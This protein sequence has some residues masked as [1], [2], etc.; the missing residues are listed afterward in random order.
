MVAVRIRA[1]FPTTEQLE[2]AVS[3]IPPPRFE[4][5]PFVFVFETLRRIKRR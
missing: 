5:G 4:N 2:N 1:F 3:E